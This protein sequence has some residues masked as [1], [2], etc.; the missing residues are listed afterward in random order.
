MTYPEPPDIDDPLSD[1]ERDKLIDELAQKVVDKRM[2]TPAILF[3]EMNKPISFLAGQSMIAAS[4]FLVPLFGTSGVRK[5]SQLLN[6]TENIEL[7]VERIE[8][9][10][11]ERDAKKRK[12]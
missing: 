12:E 11:A 8:Y 5:Y 4:P 10:S 6:N 2:E 3:L 1:E 9:L 7:I